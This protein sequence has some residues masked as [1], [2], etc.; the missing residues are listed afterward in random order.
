MT[1]RTWLDNWL[2]S[3]APSTLDGRIAAGVP[4][5]RADVIL[6]GGAILLAIL[7]VWGLRRFYVSQRNILDGFIERSFYGRG[8]A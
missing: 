4:H 3:I 5:D 8:L 1:D 6:A 2:R 7:D